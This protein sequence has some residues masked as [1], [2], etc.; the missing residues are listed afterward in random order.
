[1]INNNNN[2][3]TFLSKYLWSHDFLSTTSLFQPQP[4]VFCPLKV[5]S[6]SG[7]RWKLFFIMISKE[8]PKNKH[9][10]SDPNLVPTC[11]SASRKKCAETIDNHVNTCSVDD[12]ISRSSVQDSHG[13]QKRRKWKMHL[14]YFLALRFI[15][16]NRLWA[17]LIWEW[18]ETEE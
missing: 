13:L 17:N 15:G 14:E 9:A 4:L 18:K 8:K 16:F 12:P 5:K 6:Y 7:L 3:I 2:E 1:M 11:I 10:P